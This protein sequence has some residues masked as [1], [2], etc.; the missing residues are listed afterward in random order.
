MKR[1]VCM[2]LIAGL[3][4]MGLAGC[5][6][7]TQQT[8]SAGAESLKATENSVAETEE[9]PEA[10]DTDTG[11]SENST[12]QEQASSEDLLSGKD[13]YKRQLKP[14]IAAMEELIK[15]YRSTIVLC[16]A[17]QPALQSFFSD[18]TACLLYTSRCV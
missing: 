13:V 16:T 15:R 14:C 18:N 12:D 7:K 3:T 1:V 2:I 9:V 8:E 11:E 5:G 6:G 10:A 4:V 17:T